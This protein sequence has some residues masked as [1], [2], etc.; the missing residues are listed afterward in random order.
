MCMAYS[1][2]DRLLLSVGE[3]VQC[4][5]YTSVMTLNR[6]LSI[7]RC[8]SICCSPYIWF[9]VI[10]HTHF[11]LPSKYLL[12]MHTCDVHT[13]HIQEP[14]RRTHWLSGARGTTPCWLPLPCPMQSMRCGG[15]HA[16]HT[17]SQQL[18]PRPVLASG[19]W[20]RSWREESIS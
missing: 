16:L 18:G 19:W 14:I 11:S 9:A 6:K 20:R 8:C 7:G 2:D 17:S 13:Q 12:Y 15:T 5:M 3:S 4:Y 1:R 10:H